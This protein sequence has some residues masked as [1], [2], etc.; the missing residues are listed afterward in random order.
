MTPACLTPKTST[1]FANRSK[2]NY[3]PEAVK[4]FYHFKP[5]WQRAA[6]AAAGPFANF[7]LAV[8]A[9][10]VL[11][12]CVGEEIA[13][14]KVESVIPDTPAAHAGFQAGDL[15]RRINGRRIKDFGDVVSLVTMRAG[16][17]MVVEVLRNGETLDLN[18]TPR[19]VAMKDE[20]TGFTSTMR[21]ASACGPQPGYHKTYTPA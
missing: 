13:P 4:T 17:P 20:V 11:L 21:P 1:A 7:A 2:S 15:V 8:V 18:V 10:T 14:P 16:E 9:F 3:G 5:I 12:L 19:R 6:I